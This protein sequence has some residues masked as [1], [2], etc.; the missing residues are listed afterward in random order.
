MMSSH[1]NRQLHTQIY[2]SLL[3]A[4]VLFG[5]FFIYPIVTLGWSS[6][7]L[8]NLREMTFVGLE[9]YVRLMLDEAFLTA[10]RNT[11]VWLAVAM[12]LHV[13]LGVLVA[14][15]LSK[16]FRGWKLF[17]TFF[18]L[19]NVVSIAAWAILYRNAFNPRFGLINNILESVG[20][21]TFTRAWLSNSDTA[22]AAVIFS[23]FFNIGFY[24]IICLAEIASIPGELYES[25]RIDG[26]TETQ[27]DRYITLPLLRRVIGTCMVLAVSLSL[28]GF[29]YIFLMTR[30]GPANATMTLP[31]YIYRL[32]TVP[33]F[34][35][36]NLVGLVTLLLGF[37][38]ILVVQRIVKFREER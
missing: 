37:A 20:L 13:P 23:W 27:Q 26:A 21:E 25:A 14:I 15:I 34:G 31:F 9:N 28:V 5:L 2:I 16:Q 29:E 4:L 32:Y 33:R 18:F 30:G 3:P 12:F 19:P 36:S 38:T 6:F 11:A 22:L 1:L 7:F 35:Y 10:L 8:W 24:M 17:R